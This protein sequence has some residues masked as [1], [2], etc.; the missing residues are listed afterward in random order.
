MTD[1]TVQ[2]SPATN[3][4][5]LDED[6]TLAEVVKVGIP[7]IGGVATKVDVYFLADTTGSMNTAIT[8]VKSGI[9]KIVSTV[10][11]LGADVWFGV[12]D[13]KDFPAPVATEHPYAFA[14]R[15]LTDEVEAIKTAIDGWD[16]T[17][18]RDTPEAQLYA[19]DQLAQ[20]PGGAIGWRADSRRIVVWFGDAAGHDP[21]CK[22]ISRL[23]YDI[24]EQSVTDKLKA[25]K[26]V[27]LALSMDTNYRAPAGLDDDPKTAATGY[28]SACGEPGGT[29]GQGTRIAQATGGKLVQG[30]SADTVVDTIT[31]LVQTQITTVQNVRLVASGATAGFVRSIAPDKGHGPLNRDQDHEVSFDVSWVGNV[32]CAGEPQIFN[33]SLDVVADGHIIGAKTVKVTVPAC[34]TRPDS[35]EL[36]PSIDPSEEDVPVSRP[37]DRSG[38]WMMVHQI[39]GIYLITDDQ[40]ATVNYDIQV[41]DAD[42]PPPGTLGHL[43]VFTNQADGTYL[44]ATAMEN[45]TLKREL[46]LEA[47][48]NTV[49]SGGVGQPRTKDRRPSNDKDI[50]LQSWNLI[51]VSGDPDTYAISPKRFPDYALGIRYAN[52][53]RDERVTTIRTWGRPTF[54]QYWRLSKDPTQV[55]P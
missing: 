39:M 26:I 12:G 2:V 8:R 27:V 7:K 42:P 24:T 45:P 21:V 20:P 47:A 52:L 33:G 53:V 13:Y 23:S 22:K 36:L 11:G 31:T 48:T 18:G 29:S 4:L 19:L 25:E 14:H 15:V 43:W 37:A 17:P 40:R 28:K 6:E 16:T 10:R 32:P 1:S 51:P 38:T 30:V 9:T 49:G 50:D 3:D 54:H 55:K 34:G 46:Y 35:T 41:W 5:S 44:I